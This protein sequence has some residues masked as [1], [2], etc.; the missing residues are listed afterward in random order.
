M[1]R[2]IHDGKEVQCEITKLRHNDNQIL[3]VIMVKYWNEP[4]SP[5]NAGV[6]K[7]VRLEDDYENLEMYK[8]YFKSTNIPERSWR[9][10]QSYRLARMHAW[11]KFQIEYK[12][13]E[14]DNEHHGSDNE[15]DERDCDTCMRELEDQIENTEEA[16]HSYN[17]DLS[18]WE[19]D[20]LSEISD[21]D[22]DEE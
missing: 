20:H 6:T 5:F 2:H 16:C 14:M 4:S 13:I 10:S 7:T 9:K 12:M 17:D 19:N 21:T 18:E 8:N 1:M 22:D 15:M 11:I 3:D